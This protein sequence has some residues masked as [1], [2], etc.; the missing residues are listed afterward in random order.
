MHI[1][2]SISIRI[3]ADIRPNLCGYIGRSHGGYMGI[4]TSPPKKKTG[5]NDIKT[6]IE[7]EY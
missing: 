2:Q 3:R 5:K 6:A 1:C 7:H 4:F